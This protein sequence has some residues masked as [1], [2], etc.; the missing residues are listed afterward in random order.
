[1]KAS[2]TS[3]LGR[4]TG[5]SMPSGTIVG[6]SFIECTAMSTL[7]SKSASSNS[8]TNS[9]LPPASASGLSVIWSPVVLITSID[10]APSSDRLGLA[11]SIASFACRAW[12]RASSLPLV[13][14]LSF[15]GALVPCSTVAEP[16][17]RTGRLPPPTAR[18]AIALA[19]RERNLVNTSLWPCRGKQR[20]DKVQQG[21]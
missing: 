8:F 20:F 6:T 21:L 9:P 15:G 19:K 14:S 10:T 3:S 2:R 16:I 18:S 13:P 7:P 12:V 5:S 1:M 4:L 11:R 17:A